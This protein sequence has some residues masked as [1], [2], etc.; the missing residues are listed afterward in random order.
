[1]R[2][3]RRDGRAIP[4]TEGPRLRRVPGVSLQ[5]CAVT[6]GFRGMGRARAALAAVSIYVGGYVTEY[7]EF[8]PFG[9]QVRR[10]VALDSRGSRIAGFGMGGVTKGVID[11]DVDPSR[12]LYTITVPDGQGYTVVSR[13]L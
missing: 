1:G 11:F 8:F 10:L 4:R 9:R 13:F 7:D 12:R 2:R 5:R 3:R 6:R